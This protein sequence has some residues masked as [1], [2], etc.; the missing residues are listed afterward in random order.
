METRTVLFVDD[1]EIVLKS[2]AKS[3]TDE[4]YGKCFARNG[5][6]ALEILKQQDV[7]VLV[8]DIVMPG[9]DGIELLRTV[10]KEHPDIVC[11]VISGYALSTEDMLVLSEFGIYRLIAKSLSFDDDV[12]SVIWQAIDYYN[13]KSKNKDIT[14]E[15]VS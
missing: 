12:K 2:I 14:V 6:E 5:K 3:T 13:Q 8:T 10:T 15:I 11:M 9:M 1:D 7:H 4:S